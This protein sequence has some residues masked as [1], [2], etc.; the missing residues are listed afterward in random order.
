MGHY[1]PPSTKNYNYKLPHH[2]HSGMF[3]SQTL[4]ET[5]PLE[6]RIETFGQNDNNNNSLGVN[7]LDQASPRVVS[8]TNEDYAQYNSLGGGLN[9]DQEFYD[10]VDNREYLQQVQYNC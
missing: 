8:F 4:L 10:N 9:E 3:Q 1:Q 6:K 2:R 7:Y 5:P